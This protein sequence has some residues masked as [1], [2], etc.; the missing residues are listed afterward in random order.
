MRIP[1]AVPSAF[2][3]NVTGALRESAG[4]AAHTPSP[5]VLRTALAIND[6]LS[7]LNDDGVTALT[8]L[9]LIKRV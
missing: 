8:Q 1:V 9:G 4:C 5:A 2:A 6:L 3:R 7:Q